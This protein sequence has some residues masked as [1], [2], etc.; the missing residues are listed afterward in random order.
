MK[1]LSVD[2]RVCVDC[3]DGPVDV[4]TASNGRFGSDPQAVYERWSEFR[5]WAE[6]LDPIW[7]EQLDPTAAR[8]R[9]GAALGSPVPRPRQVLAVGFNYVDHSAELDAEPPEK[10][11]VFPKLSSCVGGPADVVE[12]PGEH[13]DWEVELVAVIGRHARNVAADAGWRYVAGVTVGQDLTDRAAQFDGPTPQFSLSKSRP[14]F[15]LIG[16]WLTTVDELDDPDDLAISCLLNGE[17]VQQAR[18][19]SLVFGVGELVAR[20]SAQVPLLPGDLIFTGTPGGVGYGRTP[21]RYLTEDDVLVSRIEG[22][23]ELTTRFERPM[24]GHV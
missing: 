4:A 15:G 24:G 20:I 10:P 5:G 2:G 16:P 3:G 14:G 8:L 9:S 22:V 19:S 1:V 17:V 12:L 11:L 7:A 21:P 6:E 18:T 13:I 23:G